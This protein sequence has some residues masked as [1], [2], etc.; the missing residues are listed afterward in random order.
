MLNTNCMNE[1]YS[2]LEFVRLLQSTPL[3][4]SEQKNNVEGNKLSLEGCEKSKAD[5]VFNQVKQSKE[6][7]KRQEEHVKICRG[8]ATQTENVMEITTRVID[9]SIIKKSISK[10]KFTDEIKDDKLIY[11]YISTQ[12]SHSAKV[13]KLNTFQ[14]K[15]TMIKT[16]DKKDIMNKMLENIN[17]VKEVLNANLKLRAELKESNKRIAL[18]NKELFHLKSDNEYLKEKVKILA[19]LDKS[20][21]AVELVPEVK[22][23][24]QIDA[25]ETICQLKKEK[26]MLE[27][28]VEYLELLVW[29]TAG[30][31]HFID[32][33]NPNNKEKYIE[34]SK[35]FE[36]SSEQESSSQYCEDKRI[37]SKEDI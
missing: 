9:E 23:E 8:R 14:S 30:N 12:R 10:L 5:I 19:K 6:K 24:K 3:K 29:R 22:G 33:C 26:T 2:T 15:P 34:D 32:I 18:L 13:S 25:A 7:A 31:N 4:N 35:E 36:Y 21:M 20:Q 37:A 16:N 28:R 27:Q 1:A 11:K 17:T